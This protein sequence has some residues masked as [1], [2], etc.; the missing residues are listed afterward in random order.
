MSNAN[1]VPVSAASGRVSDSED[2]EFSAENVGFG[3]CLVIHDPQVRASGVA[4]IVASSSTVNPTYAAKYPYAFSDTA[5]PALLET[6][7]KLSRN[8]AGTAWNEALKR[9]KVTLIGASE[10]AVRPV[11]AG[12]APSQDLNQ[13]K[14]TTA[15]LRDSLKAAGLSVGNEVLGGNAI[16]NVVV[17][18][19]TGRITISE[20]GRK[21]A[22]L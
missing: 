3:V 20:P 17:K 21:E 4:H 8:Y 22:A 6:L 19:Y 15:K 12:S 10:V 11:A 7:R 1:T 5:V 2:V 18:N 14:A 9:F 16:R 13:G